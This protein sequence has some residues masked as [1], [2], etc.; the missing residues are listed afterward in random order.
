MKNLH[1]LVISQCPQTVSGLFPLLNRAGFKIDIISNLTITKRSKFISNFYE[2]KPDFFVSKL[3]EIGIKDYDFIIACDDSVLKNILTSDLSLEQK[4]KILPVTKEKNF[5]HISSKIGLSKT[6]KEQGINT[7]AFAVAQ[8]QIQALEK[9]REI[10]YPVMLKVDFSSGGDGVFEC[11]ND[12]DIKNINPEIFS[13]PILI[14]K[15]ILGCEIDLSAIYRDENLLFFN[16]AIV[17]KVN[18][19]FG[20]SVLRTYTPSI[21]LEKELFD[22]MRQLGKAIGANG[23]VNISCII[24]SQD[25]KRYFLESDMRP[26]AWVQFGKFFA[27]DPAQKI[28]DYFLY[29]KTLENP[30]AGKNKDRKEFI[31][32][33]FL[34][35]SIKEIITNKN[36]VWKYLPVEDPKF[37]LALLWKIKIH[38]RYLV[39]FHHKIRPLLKI[40]EHIPTNFFRLIIKEKEDRMRIKQTIKRLVLLR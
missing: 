7:P 39:F 30:P 9:S 29:K 40:I 32:P 13:L 18:K 6:L 27:D 5:S 37:L 28:K 22:E 35:M 4:L 2:S 14:Q 20:P 12:S 38:E 11:N 36:S 26:N 23:F 1:A 10:G 19:K 31:L 34:R 25:G 3:Q 24:S 17:N 16:Y 21:Y 33:L 8:N 15:K